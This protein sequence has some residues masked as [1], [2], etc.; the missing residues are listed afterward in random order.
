MSHLHPGSRTPDRASN[1][2]ATPTP[3][4]RLLRAYPTPQMARSRPQ[5][6]AQTA[7]DWGRF[8]QGNRFAGSSLAYGQAALRAVI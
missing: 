8:A 4:P 7:G 2:H 3:K 6:P 1:P 5:S